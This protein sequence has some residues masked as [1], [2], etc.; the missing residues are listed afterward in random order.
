VLPLWLWLLLPL[1]LRRKRGPR[2]WR[3]CR[4]CA[5]RP[6]RPNR[7]GSSSLCHLPIKR[8]RLD[9]CRASNGSHMLNPR[10]GS[11]D[12]TIHAAAVEEA[13]AVAPP[14]GARI[15]AVRHHIPGPA[16]NRALK[17]AAEA[18]LV[19][20]L[21]LSLLLLCA[22]LAVLLVELVC[23]VLRRLWLWLRLRSNAGQEVL[24]LMLCK[25]CAL[26]SAA[27][28]TEC[29]AR[30]SRPDRN[31]CGSLRHLPIKRRR[32]DPCRAS[33]GSH[34]LNP[35]RGS[36]DSTIHAAAVERWGRGCRPTTRG[37]YHCGATPHS[38]PRQ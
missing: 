1:L 2:A 28:P 10:R 4:V 16:G 12:S 31:G 21:S 20:L 37:A 36:D 23:A 6:S 18:V 5:A 22:V 17:T 32:L 13:E 25:I 8:R 33:N 26:C 34:M 3:R 14:G 27:M 24:P 19:L 15:I 38:R 7:N 9:P 11:D 29:A 30:P 35:R